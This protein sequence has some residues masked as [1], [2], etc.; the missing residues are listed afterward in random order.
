MR[1]SNPKFVPSSISVIMVCD[2]RNVASRKK[3]LHGF[4]SP[5]SNQPSKPASH[6]SAT[7]RRRQ[8]A[9]PSA[10]VDFQAN[11]RRFALGLE[12]RIEISPLRARSAGREDRGRTVR[13]GGNT[14]DS[15]VKNSP[16]ILGE[17][18]QQFGCS[19]ARP[20]LRQ[21]NRCSGSGC[22]QIGLAE[23]PT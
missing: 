14:N 23:T 2:A 15:A 12:T 18:L 19:E 3:S 17:R 13:L 8:A 21:D 6:R 22:S 1:R 7:S 11:G 5:W 9:F 10:G 16:A 4:L 20:A